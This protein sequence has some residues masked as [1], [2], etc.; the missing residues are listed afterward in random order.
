MSD[1]SRRNIQHIKTDMFWGADGKPVST[2][3]FIK[4]LFGKLPEFFKDSSDLHKQWSHPDTRKALLDKLE[5]VGFGKD[6]LIKLRTLINA[7]DSDLL[8]VLEFIEYNKIPIARKERAEKAEA[9]KK[10]LNEKQSAFVDYIV[11]LY[12]LSGIDEL[13]TS[14]LPDLLKLKFG[15][16]PEGISALGG[17]VEARNTFFGFQERLYE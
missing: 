9:F 13:D 4:S 6:N 8:D 5:E 17:P 12:V 14:K 11:Q 15:S 16:V 2:E 3:E 10:T 7:D 1:G